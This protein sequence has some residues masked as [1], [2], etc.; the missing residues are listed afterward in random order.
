MTISLKKVGQL[1][2]TSYRYASLGLYYII[3]YDSKTIESYDLRN[4]HNDF[5]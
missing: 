3:Y 2:R 1:Q 4:D 5:H